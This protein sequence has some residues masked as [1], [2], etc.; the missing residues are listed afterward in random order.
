MAISDELGARRT[1][2]IP[3]GTLELRELGSGP[4]VVLVHGAAVNGD[5]WR[6]VAPELATRHRTVALDLPLGGHRIPLAGEP[7]LSLFG[8]AA[9]VAD[10]LDALELDDVTLVGNDTGGAI[11]QA[12]VASRPGRVARL[13]LTS[14]DAFRN[15]PPKAV[16]YLPAAARVAP[17]MWGLS[18]L[19]RWRPA[20]RTPFAY[21]WAT[22][23]PV[24]PRIMDSYLG[25]LRDD[26][27]IRRDFSRFLRA[28][29]RDDMERASNG[30]GAFA[31][32]ALVVWAADDRF[33]P[34]DHGRR[35]ADLLPQGRF[36]LVEGSRTFIP[37]D[38]PE[39]LVRLVREFLDTTTRSPA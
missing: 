39:P 29:R 27:A 17:A 3:A 15:Y 30:V 24:E 26:P 14:C 31:G 23:R 7:D 28:A 33:F 4:P 25:G 12:L 8:L 36:A 38:R 13:V 9:I 11:C 2:Q 22:H 10:V 34:R 35:L 32:P 21:G 16:A 20:Q 19:M 37:E 18:Q 1:V 6:R 5:L